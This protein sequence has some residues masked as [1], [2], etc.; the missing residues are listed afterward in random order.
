[1]VFIVVCLFNSLRTTVLIWLI[2]PLAVIGVTTGLLL[3]GMPFGFMALL[4][5]LSQI[6]D[7]ARVTP[8]VSLN[9]L[10]SERWAVRVGAVPATGGAAAAGE[11]AYR[12]AQPVELGLGLL[13]NQRRFRLDDPGPAPDGIGEDNYLLLRLRLGWG[14]TPQIALHLLG[15]VAL[16]GEVRLED[17][18][19]NRINKQDYDPAPYTGLRFVGGFW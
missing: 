14:I 3:T 2:M 4:A 5:V 11:V 7:G 8:S 15:S 9:W 6:E 12:V 17:R 19:G 16:G 10:T 13:Y 18:N 1:M